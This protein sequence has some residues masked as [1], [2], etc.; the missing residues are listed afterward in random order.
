MCKPLKPKHLYNRITLCIHKVYTF[1]Y[2]FITPLFPWMSKDV[3]FMTPAFLGFKFKK[4]ETKNDQYN[5]TKK[6]K[7]TEH[8]SSY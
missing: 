3:N 4:S 5:K 7:R 8:Y 1:M 2:Y 6:L